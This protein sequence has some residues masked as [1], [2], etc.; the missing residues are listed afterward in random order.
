MRLKTTAPASTLSN[1]MRRILLDGPF[2]IGLTLH[3]LPPHDELRAL[4]RAHG[5]ALKAGR[6]RRCWFEDRDE[7]I[8][9]LRGEP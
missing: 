4:W 9:L 2:A 3:A 7:M 6:R 5:A 1:Q 8:R